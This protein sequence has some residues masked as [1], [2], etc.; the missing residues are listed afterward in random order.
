VEN[1]D[2]QRKADCKLRET[3]SK[4]QELLRVSEG[5]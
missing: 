1:L 4:E 2:E 3:L 5:R